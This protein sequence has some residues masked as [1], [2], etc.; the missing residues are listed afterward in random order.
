MGGKAIGKEDT[1]MIDIDIEL[2]AINDE[3]FWSDAARAKIDAYETAREDLEVQLDQLEEMEECVA[4]PAEGTPPSPETV[5]RAGRELQGKTYTYLFALLSAAEQYV[6]LVAALRDEVYEHGRGPAKR[7]L[8]AAEAKVRDGLLELG[9]ERG[10]KWVPPDVIRDH[11]SVMQARNSVSRLGAVAKRLLDGELD[12][13]RQL[14]TIRA[15]LAQAGRRLS[16]GMASG[17][18][19]AVAPAEKPVPVAERQPAEAIPTGSFVSPG[20]TII[21]ATAGQ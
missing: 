20:R 6:G 13:K 8:L 19:E 5:L 21:N 15:A 1:D 3:A 16:G 9:F 18:V 11:P 4:V 10:A 17:Q 7:E 2:Q 14:P 12:V